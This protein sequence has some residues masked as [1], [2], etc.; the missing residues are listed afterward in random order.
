MKNIKSYRELNP[1]RLE[2]IKKEAVREFLKERA[3]KAG[4]AS[5]KKRFAG[6]SKKEISKMMRL[7]RMG[8]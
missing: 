5:V 1:G 3:S 7:V 4:K 6:K 2:E 8:K